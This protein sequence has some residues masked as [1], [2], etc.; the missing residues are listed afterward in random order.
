MHNNDLAKGHTTSTKSTYAQD[1][2]R[3]LHHVYAHTDIPD[4]NLVQ[5]LCQAKAV[6][7]MWHIRT[8]GRHSSTLGM[9]DICTQHQLCACAGACDYL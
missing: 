4:M 9:L 8:T 3:Q 7:V 1:S 2:K 5:E 6:N